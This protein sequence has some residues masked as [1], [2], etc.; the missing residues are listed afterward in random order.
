MDLLSELEF[1]RAL[2]YLI[3]KRGVYFVINLGEK[4]CTHSCIHED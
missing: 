4:K 3:E 1:D 2:V